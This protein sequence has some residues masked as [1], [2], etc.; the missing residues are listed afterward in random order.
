MRCTSTS[1]HASLN[2][3]APTALERFLKGITITVDVP[4]LPSAAATETVCNVK[5]MEIV[6][7]IE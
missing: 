2:Q 7:R 4:W 1:E 5:A 3:S 6:I